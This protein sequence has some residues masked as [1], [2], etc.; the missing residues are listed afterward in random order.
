M[1]SRR[2]ESRCPD[3]DTFVRFLSGNLR[4]EEN[5]RLERHLTQCGICEALVERM[6]A[7]DEPLEPGPEWPAVAA[8]LQTRFSASLQ[9][10]KTTAGKPRR[11]GLGEIFWNPIAA[12]V[13]AAALIYPAYLGVFRHQPALKAESS[14][15]PRLENTRVLQLD[16]SRSATSVTVGGEIRDEHF[17]ALLFFVPIRE[18]FRYSVT[19]ANWDGKTVAGPLEAHSYDGIGHFEVVYP[20]SELPTGQY[21]LHVTEVTPSGTGRNLDFPFSR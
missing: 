20:L 3:E 2:R 17:L 19:I 21:V 1:T 14:P 6:R 16:S 9:R 11:F 8:R 12:Y 5:E 4:D 13:L 10:E 15:P 18:G 7:F